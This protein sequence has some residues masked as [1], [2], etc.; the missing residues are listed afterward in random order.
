MISIEIK[1]SR[2]ID[3][4][5]GIGIRIGGG[6]VGAF[7]P[8]RADGL[9]ATG[10]IFFKVLNIGQHVL[11]QG[12]TGCAEVHGLVAT[13]QAIRAESFY[14]SIISGIRI[15]REETKRS[16]CLRSP[17][18]PNRIGSCLGFELIESGFGATPAEAGPFGGN[19]KDIKGSGLCANRTTATGDDSKNNLVLK[20]WEGACDTWCGDIKRRTVLIFVQSLVSCTKGQA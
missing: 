8:T 6:A 15:E 20:G 3:G 19:V 13:L 14:A 16:V 7:R 9:A 11:V 5:G 17:N 2:T 10:T 4:C 12:S 1:S 18:T